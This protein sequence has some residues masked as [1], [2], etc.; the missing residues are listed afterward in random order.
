M[1]K[2]VLIIVAAIICLSCKAEEFFT[3]GEFKYE[4]LDGKTCI[5]CGYVG[6]STHVVIP[7][8]V[9]YNGNTWIINWRLSSL[10]LSGKPIISVV[11]PQSMT[12]IYCFSFRDCTSLKSITFLGNVTIFENNAFENCGFENFQIPNTVKTIGQNVFLGCKNLKSIWIPASVEIIGEDTNGLSSIH[13]GIS[14]DCDVNVSSENKYFSSE[15]G[16]LFDKDRSQLL[17][18][19]PMKKE[20]KYQIPE[21]VRTIGNCAFAGSHLE[22]IIIPSS[23]TS[24]GVGAFDSCKKLKTISLPQLKTISSYLLYSIL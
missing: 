1:K 20:I 17:Y 11:I 13:D 6:S 16:I 19:P 21:S 3:V 24:I 18:Y 10:G 2:I 4:I 8:N 23:V 5:I 15:D 9:Y 14:F 7:D 22:E 12:T